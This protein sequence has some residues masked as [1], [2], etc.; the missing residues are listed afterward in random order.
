VV[1]GFHLPGADR[2]RIDATA[3]AL[4]EPNPAI[5]RPGHCT[6]QRA[7]CLLQ[8]AL[9]ERCQPLAVSEAIDL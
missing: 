4:R 3:R 7:V 2:E 5:V 8:Q 1:G 6:G 9:G